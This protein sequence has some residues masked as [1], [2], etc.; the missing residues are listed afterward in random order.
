VDIT[1]VHQQIGYNGHDLNMYYSHFSFAIHLCRIIPNNRL[2]LIIDG[3]S[4][5][6]GFKTSELR[7]EQLFETLDSIKWHSAPLL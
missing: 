3:A 6:E 5:P 2:L 1:I 4:L 7:E